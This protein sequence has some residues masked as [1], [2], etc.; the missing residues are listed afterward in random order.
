VKGFLGILMSLLAYSSVAQADSVLR[1]TITDF[2]IEQDEF[3]KSKKTTPLTKKERKHFEGH[4]FFPIDLNYVVEAKLQR[5]E[6]EDT[7]YMMTSSQNKK[8]YVPYATATF[9]LNDT[10]CSLI[11]Y[12]SIRLREI[13]EY[14]DYLFI[15][16]R[17]ATSGEDS[18]G[19]GRYID[20]K[21]TEEDRITINF[22]L[23]YN[24]YCAYT[25][26][27]NCTIPPAENTLNVEVR[28][29]LMTPKGH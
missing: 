6:E 24:P 14:K 17:D 2:Q 11:V 7:V 23:A 20:L 3:F 15:P 21:V 27:Y 18:Y 26:G 22:N 25:T 16:F 8:A 28:A 29:G 1:Q 5:F 13:D 19:G 4:A 12:Q 9:T 10:L